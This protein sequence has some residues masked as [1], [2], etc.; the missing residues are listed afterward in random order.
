MSSIIIRL[1]FTHNKRLK[2]LLLKQQ[3]EIIILIRL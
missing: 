1:I 3:D 2:N